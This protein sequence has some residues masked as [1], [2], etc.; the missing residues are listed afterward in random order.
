MLCAWGDGPHG[1][2]DAVCSWGSSSSSRSKS[3]KAVGGS[4]GRTAAE[5]TQRASRKGACYSDACAGIQAGLAKRIS[6]FEMGLVHI[7]EITGELHS[8]SPVESHQWAG[9]TA[10]APSQTTVPAARPRAGCGHAASR[11]GIS[12]RRKLLCR[13]LCESATPFPPTHCAFVPA[14]PSSA[15]S[16][17]RL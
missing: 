15:R 3:G 13:C 6:R 2:R 4:H 10:L 17:Q 14:W 1:V 7:A 5:T 12:A 11:G 8:E 9:R 16:E